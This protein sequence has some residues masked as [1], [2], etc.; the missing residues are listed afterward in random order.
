MSISK[1]TGQRRAGQGEKEVDVRIGP[2]RAEQVL[3]RIAKRIATET[4]IG[5]TIDSPPVD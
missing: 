3:V 2:S 4:M 5:S 1:I